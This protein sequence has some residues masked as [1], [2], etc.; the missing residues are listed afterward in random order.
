[1]SK[2]NELV[3]FDRS[4]AIRGVKFGRTGLTFEEVDEGVLV[5]V[6][7]FL[8]AVDACCAWWWGDFLAAYCGYNVKKDENDAGSQYDEIVRSEKLKQY[9]ARYSLICDREAKTLKHWRS[10]SDFYNS[11]RR[12]DE[13]SWTHHVE[14]KDGCDG[15]PSKADDW[16]DLA[17]KHKWSVGQL[18]AAIRT[19]KRAEIEPDEP[20]PQL[21]LPMELVQCR[22]YAVTAINRVDRMDEKEA[23]ALLAELKPVLAFAAALAT[24]I[25]NEV[26]TGKESLLS[27]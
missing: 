12:R 5:E 24:R 7:A 25:S 18:R 19:S 22:R 17:I 8:Q 6:G 15:D 11:S 10:V 16:L 23:Q 27:A 14:A 26:G 3:V 1:M 4:I 20:M 13:L 21:C 9:T 2:K